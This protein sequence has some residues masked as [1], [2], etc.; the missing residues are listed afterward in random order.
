MALYSPFVFDVF[1]DES[2][3]EESRECV[4]PSGHDGQCQVEDDADKRQGPVVV[5]ESGA[6]A[7]GS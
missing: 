5:L 7:G 3:D 6:P 1:V 2:S 4:V